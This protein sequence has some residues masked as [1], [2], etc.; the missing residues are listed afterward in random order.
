MGY[1]YTYM[2]VHNEKVENMGIKRKVLILIVICLNIFFSSG[3]YKYQAVE[4]LAIA[5]GLG[6]DIEKNDGVIYADT[7]ETLLFKGNKQISNEVMT[8]RS[9]TIYT[10]QHELQ[11]KMPKKWVLGGE[12]IYIIS[13][14]RAKFGIKDL[15]DALLR[16]QIRKDNAYIVISKQ[17]AQDVF[18]LK[19]HMYSTVS[20]EVYSSLEYLYMENFF[21]INN[22]AYNVL[23][24][25]YQEGRKIV[26]PYIEI[27]ENR[28]Q[29]TG[30]AL[31]EE[32]K[33]VKKIDM[34]EARLINL[35]RNNN[36]ISSIGI[37]SEK[38]DEYYDL[39]CKSKLKVKVIYDEDKFNYDITINI[40]AELV[41]D[42]I[43]KKILSA[44]EAPKIENLVKKHLEKAL[45]E[46]I[47][48]MQSVYKIDWLD[49]GK[50]AAAEFGRNKNYSSDENFCDAKINVNVKVKI[51]TFG[52]VQK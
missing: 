23:Q 17:R 45:D 40:R 16:N 36:V 29:V 44:K 11:S 8:G 19:P 46:E 9:N 25:Y 22:E 6:Y 37:T 50:Y 32:D 12:I 34:G 42:S 43:D 13:E 51:S 35:L 48:K 30:L 2:G 41:T 39:I 18:N 26:I 38:A 4:E 1:D 52:Q 33:M 7:S 10:T 31:F 21:K 27:I 28:I 3:C 20:E 24:M 5:I 49:L 14:E 15:I 47:E